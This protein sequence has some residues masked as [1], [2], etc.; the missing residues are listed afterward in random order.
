MNAPRDSVPTP[1]IAPP[2]AEPLPPLPPPPGAVPWVVA[3]SQGAVVGQWVAAAG[4]VLL[5]ASLFLAGWHHVERIEVT[6][7][8]Y[9][10]EDSYT[11]DALADFTNRYSMAVWAYLHRGLATPLVVAAVATAVCALLAAG[12]G[13]RWL[14]LLALSGAA[15]TL[16]LIALDVRQLPGTLLLMAASRYS[17][18]PSEVNAIGVRPGAMMIVALTGIGL[19]VVGS[20][21]ALRAGASVRVGSTAEPPHRQPHREQ[22]PVGEF[23]PRSPGEDAIEYAPALPQDA[24]HERAG[25]GQREDRQQPP[26]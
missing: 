20:L 24:P 14:P 7:N 13:R 12:A 25:E 21:G 11:G 10:F 1:L 2:R 19:I 8:D 22:H 26:S 3:P 17:T 6:L 23:Q 18:A 16:A 5:I 4:G 9:Q 15:A